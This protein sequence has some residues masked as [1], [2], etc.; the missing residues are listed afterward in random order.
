MSTASIEWAI[1][2]AALK[3]YAI[4]PFRSKAGDWALTAAAWANARYER[5][6]RT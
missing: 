1:F 3:V 5:R 6:M 2:C 4:L